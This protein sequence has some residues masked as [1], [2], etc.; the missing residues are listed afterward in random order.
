MKRPSL[1]SAETDS[2]I[3]TWY[4]NRIEA[5]QP[6]IQYT[7]QFHNSDY[8]FFFILTNQTDAFQSCTNS[9]CTLVNLICILLRY[10][11]P[12]AAIELEF[13]CICAYLSNQSCFVYARNINWRLL[14]KCIIFYVQV[15][16]WKPNCIVLAR[17][18]FSNCILLQCVYNLLFTYLLKKDTTIH[19]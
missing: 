16:F 13:V 19:D 6:K 18:K 3:I 12:A 14:R 17:R 7:L 1:S 8:F 15:S 5:R 4:N 9:K 10:N 11:T 2:N